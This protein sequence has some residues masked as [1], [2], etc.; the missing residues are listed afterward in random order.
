MVRRGVARRRPGHRR[1]WAAG[2]GAAALAVQLGLSPGA[3]AAP[4]SPAPEG[5][6]P[7]QRP[8]HLRPTAPPAPPDAAGGPG[9][10]AR[11]ADHP[12]PTSGTATAG[13]DAG[14]PAPA[15]PRAAGGPAPQAG[16]ADHPAPTPASASVEQDASLGAPAPQG[17][18]R[19]QAP[20]PAPAL[21]DPADVSHEPPVPRAAPRRAAHRPHARGTTSLIAGAMLGGA[22]VLARDL[23]LALDLVELRRGTSS[24]SDAGDHFLDT[25]VLVAPLQLLLAVPAAL[26]ASGAYQGGRWRA[27][28]EPAGSSPQRSLRRRAAAGWALV[29]AGLGLLALDAGVLVVSG[30]SDWLNEGDRY[31]YLHISLSLVGTG[32][33]ATGLAIGPHAA[34]RLRGHRERRAF[35][36]TVTPLTLRAGGGV[37]LAGRW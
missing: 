37:G 12:A 9:S 30:V 18:P 27:R 16:G 19:A 20:A 13:Q 4:A 8:R 28:V 2:P 34:G 1:A 25:P 3:W 11:S 36:W 15:R 35:T 26:I 21:T 33:L 22:M 31:P 23:V 14:S 6:V 17:P 29:G 24:V 10:Q 5:P 32:A 7:V